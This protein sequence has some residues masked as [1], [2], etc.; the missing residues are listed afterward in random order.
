MDIIKVVVKKGQMPESCF[1]C[2]YGVL[3]ENSGDWLCV[4]ENIYLDNI[5]KI[6]GDCPLEEE[7]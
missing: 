1:D 3:E 5:D 4:I 7:K 2:D 6:D